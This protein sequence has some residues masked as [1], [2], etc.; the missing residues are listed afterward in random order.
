MPSLNAPTK[1]LGMM[2]KRNCAVV[3]R[4]VE[5]L[6]DRQS[7]E[8]TQLDAALQMAG[9]A[10]ASQESLAKVRLVRDEMKRAIDK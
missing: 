8:V 7:K 4:C 9:E 6:R 3:R 5:K 10:G 1:V 2:L